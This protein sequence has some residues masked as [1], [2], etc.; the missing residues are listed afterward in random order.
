MKKQIFTLV[1]AMMLGTIACMAQDGNDKKGRPDNSQRIEQM[2]AELGLDEAQAAEFMDIMGSLMPQGMGPMGGGPRGQ[3]PD[4]GEMGEGQGPGGQN[5]RAELTEEQREEMKAKMETMREEMQAKFQ[6]AD[7]RLKN[8]LTDEQ[9]EKVKNMI[10][11]GPGQGRQARG[12]K[13]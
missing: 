3:R 1:A 10:G 9:Y 11:R 13:Q 6:Q 12:K 5:G 4:G 8:L 2:V 7:E